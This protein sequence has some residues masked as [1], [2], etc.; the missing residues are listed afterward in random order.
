MPSSEPI[1]RQARSG[2]ARSGQSPT[3]TS[4]PDSRQHRSGQPAGTVIRGRRSGST[5][6][7]G[8]APGR[9]RPAL[10]RRPAAPARNLPPRTGSAARSRPGSRPPVQEPRRRRSRSI[11]ASSTSASRTAGT[12]WPRACRSGARRAIKAAGAMA[13]RI[14][15]MAPRETSAV[16]HAARRHVDGRSPVASWAPSSTSIR[17]SSCAPSR[18]RWP[19]STA[20]PRHASCSTRTSSSRCRSRGRPPTATRTSASTGRSKATR[21]CR[22][23]DACCATSTAS[24]RPGSRRRSTRSPPRWT[25]SCPDFAAC[26]RPK[27]GRSR[28]AR[29]VRARPC[30]PA[31]SVV[32]QLLATIEKASRFRPTGSVVRV[33]GTTV[34]AAGLNV[35]VGSICWIEL[36]ADGLVS[37]EVVGFKDGRITLVPFGDLSGVRPGSRVRLREHQFQVPVGPARAGP[38]PRR[39]RPADRRPGTAP[40]RAAGHRRPGPQPAHAGEDPDA[41]LDRR[42]GHRRP[43]HDG[44]GPAA[45]ASS[46]GP[47]SARAR[48]SG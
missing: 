47:A 44:Q 11:S 30:T 40:G 23:A 48:S 37:A 28:D 31:G 35:R 38:R 18:P 26:G 24:C 25:R 34:E 1:I 8:T 14:E 3:V 43:A 29:R 5:P 4:R 9:P 32:G 42:P 45:R 12:R 36:E 2:G 7:A 20:R 10:R 6:A 16:A 13:A 27:P 33:V 41:A 39:I 15:A 17:P 46:P 21:P 22:R 19:G